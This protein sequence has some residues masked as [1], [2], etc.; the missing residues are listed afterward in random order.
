MGHHSPTRSG[1]GLAGAG[2]S[3]R[4]FHTSGSGSVSTGAV[5][6]SESPVIQSDP[7]DTSDNKSG[8]LD[9]LHNIR[10]KLEHNQISRSEVDKS[11]IFDILNLH[12]EDPDQEIQH[13]ALQLIQDILPHLGSETDTCMSIITENLMS[14]LGSHS[15]ILRKTT[16]HIL[17]IYLRFSS[18]VQ[19]V[20]RCIVNH[21]L[22]SSDRRVVHETLISVPI[23]FPPDFDSRYGNKN[24]YL[25]VSGLARRLVEVD[26]RMAAFIS[27][28][29]I[30]DVVGTKTFGSYISKLTPDQKKIY[31]ELEENRTK[32][33]AI[34]DQSSGIIGKRITAGWVEFGAI[35]HTIIEK[36]Q[37]EDEPRVRLQ[38]AEELHRCIRNMSDFSPL[39]Q[40]IRHFL[41]FLESI[42]DE[43]NFKMNLLI[44][45]I[46]Q[47]LLDQLKGKLKPNIRSFVSALL[48][49]AS[50][51]KV[52]VR[53][54]KLQSVGKVD[55]GDETKHCDQPSSGSSWRQEGHCERVHPQHDHVR[56]SHLPQ[57]RVR[58][59]EHRRHRGPHPGRPQETC[60][61]RGPGGSLHLGRLPRPIQG[62]SAD[63]SH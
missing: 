26:T 62:S 23:L 54:E 33:D 22:E 2:V 12:L 27:M 42:L 28:Q 11:E 14:C 16:V 17:Q 25:L 32:N 56:S 30:S 40:Q 39:S 46:Y 43:R 9:T 38:G 63:Q 50:N 45:E 4:K 6:S 34:L 13:T 59:E 1:D 21:G 8:K 24:L 48:K 18:D 31:D 19:A 57:Q 20:I 37:N 61:T 51:S 52:V 15:V 55:A 53:I 35:D 7:G 60:Q 29:K 58:P 49:H 36:L 5:T 47:I 10:Y 3:S 41:N 44:L